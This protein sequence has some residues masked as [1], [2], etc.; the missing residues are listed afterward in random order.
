ME[1][2]ELL[3]LTEQFI[4]SK[5][6]SLKIQYFDIYYSKK[7]QPE[8]YESTENIIKYINKIVEASKEFDNQIL[9]QIII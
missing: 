1:K 3:K 4:Y 7:I 6:D 2:E 8:I 5:L 9:F